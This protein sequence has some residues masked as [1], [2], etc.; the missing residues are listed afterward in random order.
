MNGDSATAI[1]HPAPRLSPTASPQ[2]TC[3]ESPSAGES[4]ER[5]F[6]QG[7]LDICFSCGEKKKTN[8]LK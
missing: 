8:S 5:L 1:C 7:S 3:S 2:F 4:Q 6:F